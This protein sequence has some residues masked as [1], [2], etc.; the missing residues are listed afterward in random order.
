MSNDKGGCYAFFATVRPR[1]GI[2][3]DDIANCLAYANKLCQYY[4]FV[5]EK[6]GEERHGHWI[7]FPHIAQQRSNVVSLIAKHCLKGWK[8]DEIQNFKRWDRRTGNGCVKTVTSLDL[9]TGYLDG[10]YAKKTADYFEVVE[11]HLPEDLHELEKWIPDV[12]ALKR[13]PNVRFH[14][15][16]KQ[17][18]EHY[19]IPDRNEDGRKIS[20][21]LMTQMFYDLEN[22]DVRECIVD[23]RMARNFIDRFH[24]WYNFY[25]HD[26]NYHPACRH[27]L[28]SLEE[29]LTE[30][31]ECQ[32]E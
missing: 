1:H 28:Q 14:T 8:D 19:K 20:L 5:I 11:E 2:T 17:M 21:T 3:D 9:I 6:E 22:K 23:A 7:L 32:N 18:I 25:R 27:E 12:G 29:M 4:L 30:Y 26:D 16:L 31:L 13:R 15:L 10:T 24:R